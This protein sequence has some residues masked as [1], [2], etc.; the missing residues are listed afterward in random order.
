M[1]PFNIVRI[2]LPIFTKSDSKHGENPGAL[3]SP[4]V[5]EIHEFIALTL[6]TKSGFFSFS[7][8]C[9]IV[10]SLTL[11]SLISLLT[12]VSFLFK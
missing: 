1:R 3:N 2:S 5:T 10:F 7:F 12:L 4:T 11:F 8:A 9:P 6:A